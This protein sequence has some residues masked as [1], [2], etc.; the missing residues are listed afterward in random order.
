MCCAHCPISITVLPVIT[1]L[2]PLSVSVNSRLLSKIAKN[3]AVKMC[4]ISINLTV[5]Q[6]LGIIGL[7]LTA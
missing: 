5:S 7:K 4:F 2:L 1:F 6:S 3:G